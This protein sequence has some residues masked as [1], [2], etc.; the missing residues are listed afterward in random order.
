MIKTK[1]VAT[2]MPKAA[3]ILLDTPKKGQRPKNLTNT[4]LLTMAAPKNKNSK[5]AMKSCLFKFI[6]MML[7]LYDTARW[8]IFMKKTFSLLNKNQRFELLNLLDK[9]FPN[10][11]SELNFNNPFE[12]LC[13]VV[14]SAQATDESV[15]KITPELFKIAPDAYAMA[16]LSFDEVGAIVKTIGL[17]KAK[18]QYLVK[19]SKELCD[20]YEGTVPCDYDKLIKLPGV[21]S[22]TA[23]VVLNVAFGQP[24]IAVDTHIFRVCN[25]TGFCEG[26]NAQEVEQRVVPLVDEKF[27]MQAHHLFLLHGRYVC[28]A[29]KPECEHCSIKLIC[30][31]IGL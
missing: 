16:K 2:P 24:T 23:K 19:L 31:K 18:S 11:K 20:K 3:E 4:K 8:P 22:K 30:K 25:R 15:N 10:P 26:K 17:W 27:I 5:C 9:D 29:R 12:L 1:V 13:A 14:L 28:K 21:G 6:I 7:T